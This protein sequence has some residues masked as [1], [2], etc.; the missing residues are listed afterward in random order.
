[1]RLPRILRHVIDRLDE[2]LQGLTV[3]ARH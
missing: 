3:A 2:Q 1:M